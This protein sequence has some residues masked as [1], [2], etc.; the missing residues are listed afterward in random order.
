MT[1][2]EPTR[3]SI[4][5]IRNFSKDEVS[6]LGAQTF[7]LALTFDVQRLAESRGALQAFYKYIYFGPKLNLN[8]SRC[9]SSP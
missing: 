6:C 7:L 9:S 1:W 5:P 2:N 8:H 3:P 4:A